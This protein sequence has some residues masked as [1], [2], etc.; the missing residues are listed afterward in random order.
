MD[1]RKIAVQKAELNDRFIAVHR[2]LCISEHAKRAAPQ[3]P[4]PTIRAGVSVV[5]GRNI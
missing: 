1:E 2:I 5:F 3:C 4:T